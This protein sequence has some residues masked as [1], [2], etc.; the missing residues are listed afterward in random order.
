M[1]AT[2]KGGGS[3]NEDDDNDEDNVEQGTLC[4]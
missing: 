4:V 2:A 1:S 3:Y